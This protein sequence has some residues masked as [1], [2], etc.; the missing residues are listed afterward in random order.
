M[1]FLYLQNFVVLNIIAKKWNSEKKGKNEI[2]SANFCLFRDILKSASL[3]V[4]TKHP[5]SGSDEWAQTIHFLPL[6]THRAFSGGLRT[7]ERKRKKKKKEIPRKRKKRKK[8]ERKK[9]ER[10][11]KKE[12]ERI[13]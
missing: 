8:R 1:S 13:E 3:V 4:K 12:K 5:F 9:K 6:T 11:R 10:K 7:T 2:V